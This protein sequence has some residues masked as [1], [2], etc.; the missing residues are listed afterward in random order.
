[1]VNY[2]INE[3]KRLGQDEG[4]NDMEIAKI[5]GCSRATINRTRR[6]Y[7]IPKANLKNKRDKSYVCVDCKKTVY[8]RRC[9]RRKLLCPECEAKNVTEVNPN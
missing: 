8:I 5:L 9:E 7:D 3:I 2:V 1:M 4:L 6:E